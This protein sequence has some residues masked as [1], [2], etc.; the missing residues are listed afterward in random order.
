MEYFWQE[1]KMFLSNIIF[2]NLPN[3]LVALLVFWI[4]LKLIKWFNRF[5][6]RFY[7]RKNVDKSLRYFLRTLLNIIL[8]VLLILTVMDMIGIEATSFIAMLGAAGLA[9]G[10]AL[11]GTLQNFAG[12]VIILA[13][14]PYRV[15]DYIE[16]GSYKGFVLNIKIFNTVLKTFDN[17]EITGNAKFIRA[18]G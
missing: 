5:L 12:G 9:I 14:K 2:K 1:A 11:Q 15:G 18:Y 16:Q 3:L 8:R 7:E 6:E 17:T 10:M 13:L 4:G